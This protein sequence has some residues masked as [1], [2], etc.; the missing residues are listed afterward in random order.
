MSMRFAALLVALT[1]CYVNNPPPPQQ[2]AYG[3]AA[4]GYAPAPVT[5]QQGTCASTPNG[6]PYCAN[7]YAGYPQ[8]YAPGYV[9]DGYPHGTPERNSYNC[10][11]GSNA[12]TACGYDCR[13]GL[14]GIGACA[15]EPGGQC[16]Q[17]SDGHV[18]CTVP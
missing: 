9:G 2:P 4:P 11:T 3:Y 12:M 15:A 18:Y 17:G 13:I 14:D 6:Q 7:G 10:V 1:A 16:T 5:T 8:G